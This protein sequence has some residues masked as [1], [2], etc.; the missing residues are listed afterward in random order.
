[1]QIRMQRRGKYWGKNWWSH[2]NQVPPNQW[3]STGGGSVHW[4]P[5]SLS[6]TSGSQ[7][8]VVLHTASLPAFPGRVAT[9]GETVGCYNWGRGCTWHWLSTGPAKHPTTLRAAPET[10]R[11][12]LPVCTVPWR[13]KPL[14][15][16]LRTQAQITCPKEAAGKAMTI[17]AKKIWT[18]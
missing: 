2:S 4:P 9:S 14:H 1:M 7:L 6:Q 17:W 11:P 3:F 16:A 12:R 18:S 10:Q 13:G 5:A 8:G 15:S